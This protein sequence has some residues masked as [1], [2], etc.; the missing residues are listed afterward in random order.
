MISLLWRRMRTALV[1]GLIM[2][3]SFML[4]GLPFAFCGR[5]ERHIPLDVKDPSLEEREEAKCLVWYEEKSVAA[6][7]MMCR[8]E[9][10]CG[11][12]SP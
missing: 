5:D 1:I 2:P 4:L 10:E 12:P 3:G 6:A 7:G 9:C 8:C 11:A